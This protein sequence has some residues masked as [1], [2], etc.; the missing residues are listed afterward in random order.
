MEKIRKIDEYL[1]AGF[2][3]FLK[4]LKS[5]KE[6]ERTLLDNSMI[7]YGSG[8]SDANR[9]SHDD[10][11][12]VIAGKGGGSITTGRHIDLGEEVPL[13]NLFLSMLDRMDAGVDSIGDSTGRLKQLDG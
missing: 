3:Y 6:G 1:A 11:P 4:K 10:L 7:V 5:V 12:I 2:A 9:H 8:L 13:N